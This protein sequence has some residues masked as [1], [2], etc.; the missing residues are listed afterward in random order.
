MAEY[1]LIKQA[2]PQFPVKDLVKVKDGER[3]LTI[4]IFGPNYFSNNVEAM[5]ET[6]SHPQTGETISFREPTT[7]ESI[8]VASCE[9]GNKREFDI[10]R[11][12][13]DPR[14]LQ[15]GRIVRTSEGVFTNTSIINNNE[16]NKLLSN[17]KN[18]EGIYHIDNMAFAP[19]ESFETGVQSGKDF[20]QGGLARALE[21]SNAKVA[22]Q[23]REIVSKYKEV[24]VFGFNPVSEPLQRVAS[25]GSI[26]DWDRLGVVGDGWYGYDG[27]AFGVLDKSRSDAISEK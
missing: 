16:L 25:L 22:T 8:F 18:V 1:E 27:C 7:S 2:K 17:A 21:N 19:Y 4:G 5:N 6:Y 9:F 15:T 12:I 20:A 23:L 13:F 26:L 10:K 24:N 3:A 14:W 11:D